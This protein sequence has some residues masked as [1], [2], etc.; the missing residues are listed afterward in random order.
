MREGDGQLDTGNGR[1][2]IQC[3]WKTACGIVLD[4]EPLDQTGSNASASEKHETCRALEAAALVES[5]A[6]STTSELFPAG[7]RWEK[8]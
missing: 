5:T 2:G 8:E 4:E 3:L 6:G 7:I 1:P